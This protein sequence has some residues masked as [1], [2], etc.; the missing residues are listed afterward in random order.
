MWFFEGKEFTEEEIGGSIGFVYLITNLVTQR[1]Y[2]GK[3]LFTA[4][5]T[6]QVNG[7]KKKT[8]VASNWNSYYGSN[9]ELK[10]DV[11]ALGPQNFR[12]DILHI[13]K[14]K[15]ECNYLEAK[16]QFLRGVMESDDFYNY[17]IMVR[18]HK[19]HLKNMKHESIQ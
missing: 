19:S 17:W 18:V 5:K 6:K 1:K 7:K 14:A 13:C 2:V 11:K 10:A 3:K 4:A 12:R 16:E 15:G 8:R 9:D